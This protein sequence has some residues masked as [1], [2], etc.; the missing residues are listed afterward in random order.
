[1]NYRKDNASK[2]SGYKKQIDMASELKEEDKNEISSRSD[3]FLFKLRTLFSFNFILCCLSI[4]LAVII[5]H[6]LFSIM[7]ATEFLSHA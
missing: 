3:D 7:A 5:N 1:M 6:I 2:W 4:W